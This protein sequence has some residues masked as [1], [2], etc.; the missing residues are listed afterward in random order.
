VA[1]SLF[2]L[3]AVALMHDRLDEAARRFRDSVRLGRDTGDKED[4]AWCL[5]GIAGYAAASGL[6]PQA[7]VLLGAADGLL[8]AMGAAFKP[9]E[10]RLHDDT[11]DRARAM[12]TR[13]AFESDRE[14]GA[15]MSLDDA[16]DEA[17]RIL[18]AGAAP[19]G[20]GSSEP[21]GRARPG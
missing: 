7:A 6:G 18:A 13:D 19:A 12:T 11:L 14:R 3:G 2:N 4:L 20:A 8:E 10:R 5:L 1:R 17:L 21:R 16:I 9:F 15:A